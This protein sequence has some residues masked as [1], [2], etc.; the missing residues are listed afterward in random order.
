MRPAAATAVRLLA[1]L[2][3][4]DPARGQTA[5]DTVYSVELTATASPMFNFFRLPKVPGTTDESSLG[6]GLSL[7]GMWHPARL[8]AVGFLTGYCVIA[9]DEIAA[10]GEPGATQYDATLSAVPLQLA[11]SMQK[12]GFEFGMGIGPYLMMSSIGGG[13]GDQV[14]GERLELGMTFFGSYTFSLGDM[15]RLGPEL[16]V[17]SLRYRGIVSVMP[18]L[19]VRIDPVR[20]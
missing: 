11:L 16:R 7:R 5:A 20:Y 14:E 19:S 3:A 6:Y 9:H 10:G 17:V 12:A 1:C 13:E 18:S 4:S 15:V 8:L 2:L